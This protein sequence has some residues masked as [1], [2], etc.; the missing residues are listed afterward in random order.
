MTSVSEETGP[1]R[2]YIPVTAAR[3]V[4]VE[5]IEE[6]L[7]FQA[8][9]RHIGIGR[10]DI[11]FRPYNGKG[12]L[13]DFLEA[14]AIDPGFAVVRSLAVVADA[15]GDRRSA[16]ARIRGALRNAGLAAPPEPLRMSADGTPPR[17]GWLI[18]PHDSPGRMLED[19]CLESVKG[20]PAMACVDE[21]L[22]CVTRSFPDFPKENEE[23]KARIHAFLSSR[24]RPDLRLGEAAQAGVWDFDAPSFAPLKHLLRLL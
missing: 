3:Q 15:D 4:L 24:E 10:N 11:Q 6:V 22:Q 16:A 21:F 9:A 17:T 18:I 8:L 5:G 14:F 13:R 19:V 20:D 7:V 1:A 12:N 2:S 23:P